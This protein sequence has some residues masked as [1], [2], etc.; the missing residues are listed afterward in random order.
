M[1]AKWC[2]FRRGLNVLNPGCWNSDAYMQQGT[3]SVLVQFMIR[4]LVGA[5]P[6]I[7]LMLLCSYL[8][9]DNKRH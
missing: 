1:S 9:P 7:E 6:L 8:D 3:E 2:T 4:H 5:K